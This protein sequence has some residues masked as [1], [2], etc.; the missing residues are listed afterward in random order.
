M[1]TNNLRVVSALSVNP[2]IEV[3]IVGGIVRGKT[4]SVVGA[5][6]EAMLAEWHADKGFFGAAGL[7]REKGLTDADMRE[8]QVKRAMIKTVNEVNVL[9]DASKLGQQAFLTFAKL[10]DIDHLFSD[11]RI[12]NAYVDLCQEF[13]IQLSV[14]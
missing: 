3:V 11:D 1:I 5:S 4:A 2:D 6:A 13:G 10:S 12:T 9:L 8:V 7:V 14:V